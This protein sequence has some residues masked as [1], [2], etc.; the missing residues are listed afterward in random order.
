MVWML[1]WKCINIYRT[2]P[3]QAYPNKS[4]YTD[5]S[6]SILVSYFHPS[7]PQIWKNE[8][9]ER[10]GLPNSYFKSGSTLPRPKIFLS[11]WGRI[12]GPKSVAVQRHHLQARSKPIELWQCGYRHVV[13]SLSGTQTNLSGGVSRRPPLPCFKWITWSLPLRTW[14]ITIF[15]CNIISR[16]PLDRSHTLN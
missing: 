15:D 4:E 13:T 3:S 16:K 1:L 14:P 7:V 5:S 8:W 6:E 10:W 9:N 12:L 11:V 2:G